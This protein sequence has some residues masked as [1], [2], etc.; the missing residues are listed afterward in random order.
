MDIHGK[1]CGCG[2][3]GCLETVASLS[4]LQS[5]W[6][7]VLQNGCISNAH[8]IDAV[9]ANHPS[10]IRLSENAVNAIGRTLSNCLNLVGIEQILLYGPLCELGDAGLRSIREAIASHPFNDNDD[11]TQHQTQVIFGELSTSQ[12]LKGLAYLFIEQSLN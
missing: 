9:L 3:R 2:Q 4:A 10:A 8:F 1:Q 7:K 11:L 6:D 12:Q 5:E